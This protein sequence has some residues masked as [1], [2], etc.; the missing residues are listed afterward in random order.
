MEPSFLAYRHK[1]GFEF[2]FEHIDEATPA[3]AVVVSVLVLN[4][5]KYHKRA[6]A[7]IMHEFYECTI[8][9]LLPLPFAESFVN[10]LKTLLWLESEDLRVEAVPYIQST[11]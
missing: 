5:D 1:L 7:E 3:N 11:T 9:D 4:L 8:L 6:A 2:K 10:R